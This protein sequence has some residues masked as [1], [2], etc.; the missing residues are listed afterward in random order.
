M[1]L[2]DEF[3]SFSDSDEQ[4]HAGATAIDEEIDIEEFRA[5]RARTQAACPPSI[6]PCSI[7]PACPAFSSFIV[8]PFT[9]LSFSPHSFP[10][11]VL[12]AA[13]KP[14]REYRYDAAG[15]QEKLEAIRLRIKGIEGPIPFLETLS[16]TPKDPLEVPDVEDDLERERRLYGLPPPSFLFLIGRKNFLLHI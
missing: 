15:L 1:E 13:K 11:L 9:L 12:P 10:S 4:N 16:V 5:L 8:S 6:C 14:P 3:D 2:S 7:L